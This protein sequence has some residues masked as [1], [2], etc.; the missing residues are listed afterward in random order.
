MET[1]KF[2]RM[3][4]TFGRCRCREKENFLAD[5]HFPAVETVERLEERFLDGEIF[6]LSFQLI[7]TNNFPPH[8]FSMTADREKVK[9]W[10]RLSLH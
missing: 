4:E 5:F 10:Q 1:E 9:M 2:R 8:T 6:N 7:K 3:K